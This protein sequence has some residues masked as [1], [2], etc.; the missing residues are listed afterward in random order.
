MLETKFIIKFATIFQILTLKLGPI[1]FLKCG[2][3]DKVRPVRAGTSASNAENITC[4]D[5]NL[6]SDKSRLGYDGESQSNTNDEESVTWQQIADTSDRLCL[7]VYTL[8]VVFA[9]F[10]FCLDIQGYL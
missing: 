7:Y 6:Q 10:F 2:Q 8:A 1:I 4:A 9:L 3:R 5:I